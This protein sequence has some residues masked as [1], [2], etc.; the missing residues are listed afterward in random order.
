MKGTFARRI[1]STGRTGD[2]ISLDSSSF[3]GTGLRIR[4][5]DTSRFREGRGVLRFNKEDHE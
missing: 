1:F 2:T 5:M 3:L 4:I